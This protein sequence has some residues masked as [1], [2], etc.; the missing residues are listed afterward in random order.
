MNFF[1]TVR[2]ALRTKGYAYRTE[3]TYMHWIRQYVRFIQPTH[4]RDAGVDGVK[5]FLTHLAVDLHVSAATQ[6]QALAA[7]LFVY[8]L[9]GIELGDLDIV[10]AKKSTWLPTVLT[11]EEAMRL[12]EQLNGQYRIMGQLMYGGG[13]RLME[14]LRLRI[15][16][17]D[18]DMQTITLRD[19][20]SNRDRV[21]CLPASVIPA[22]TLHLAK[23]KAQHNADLADGRGEVELPNALDRKYPSAPFEW[24]WQ[25][26]F[27]ALGFSTDPRSG[28]V[29]R[30]HV[31][32]TS[33]QKAVKL[34]ARKAGITKPC[35]PHTLRHS[36]AT[37]L[38]ELG[39]DI[40]TI[41]ELLGHKDVKTT[42][43]YTH[44]SMRG[45]GVVSPLDS[46]ATVIKRTVAVEL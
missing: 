18:F 29:R 26:V 6:G 17:V 42:M 45:S 35:G 5:R 22:L 20:K 1:E 39:N 11:H 40:R 34:A 3:K 13:L 19:T 7:L 32:E 21:T 43:V 37:R 33:I 46:G 28:H 14:V 2:N 9:Y 31:Y 27:P 4:P 12:L 41:Q 23:V 10:R 25:Y 38:L 44:V 15:K 8:K 16:D 24:G 30:H 36:F